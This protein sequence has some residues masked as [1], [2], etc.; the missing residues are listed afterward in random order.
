MQQLCCESNTFLGVELDLPHLYSG[1]VRDM[2]DGGDD[3]L[4]IVASDRL[5]AFDVVMDEPVPHKGRVLTAISAFWFEHLRHVAP[6]HLISTDVSEFP[7][8]AQRDE[9]AGRSMHV[10]RAEMLPIECIVRGYIS[11]SGWREYQESGT[12]HGEAMPE[13]LVHSAKL[14]EPIFTPSTKA[15]D[16]LHDENINFA[17]AVEMVGADIAEQA[18]EMSLAL[19]TEAAAWAADRGIILADTKFELGFVDGQ[20]VVADEMLTPDSSRYW[21]KDQWQPGTVPPSYDK[22]PV[23]DFLDGL[24][25]DKSPPPPAVPD[26]VIA[27]TS[28]RYIEGYETI[29]GLSFAEWPG[30]V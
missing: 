27:A 19:Y 9:L 26:D 10:R 25:W 20:L 22:Q 7:A 21:P 16:G 23:R 3:S 2:Y 5:S 1:K 30:S 14:P 18:R 12:V 11:G 29:T 4:V 8:G 28:Q 17:R 15:E 24:D 13:G 6:N